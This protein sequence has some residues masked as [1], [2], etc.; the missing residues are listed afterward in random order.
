MRG[1]LEVWLFNV[2]VDV[3][4]L[5]LFICFDLCVTYNKHCINLV[6]VTIPQQTSQS[7]K[8]DF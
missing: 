2:S 8:L 6:K 7:G 1:A 3:N 5:K 4:L